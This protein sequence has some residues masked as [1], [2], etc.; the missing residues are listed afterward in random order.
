MFILEHYF[1]FK[2]F[3]SVQEGQMNCLSLTSARRRAT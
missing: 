3:A 1:A 2:M